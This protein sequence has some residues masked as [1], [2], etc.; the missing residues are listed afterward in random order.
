MNATEATNA[1]RSQGSG[2]SLFVD[3]SVLVAVALTQADAASAQERLLGADRRWASPL[4]RAEYAA[5]CVR[6]RLE[7]PPEPLS[8]LHWTTDAGSLTREIDAVLST[9][10]VR[11]ADC[12]HL[13]TALWLAPEPS[14]LTFFTLDTRQR[15]VADR[16]GF[17][18]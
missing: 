11:G 6:E 13:A 14:E 4:L 16:L 12:W 10:Y 3:S 1:G 7:A 5:A 9:G 18:T 8:W 17:R 2:E 15:Q